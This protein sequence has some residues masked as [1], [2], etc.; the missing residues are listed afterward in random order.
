MCTEARTKLPH[1]IG[2]LGVIGMPEMRQK[3]ESPDQPSIS[4]VEPA[5]NGIWESTVIWGWV[6]TLVP[7]EPQNSW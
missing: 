3:S 2:P 7:S 6:K 1:G 4:G 5:K